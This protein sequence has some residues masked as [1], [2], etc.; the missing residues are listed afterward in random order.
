MLAPSCLCSTNQALLHLSLGPPTLLFQNSQDSLLSCHSNESARGLLLLLGPPPCPHLA[1]T[2]HM[3]SACGA[4]GL[5]SGQGGLGLGGGEPPPHSS[6]IV[7]LG[8]AP[9]E[10]GHSFKKSLISTATF[11]CGRILF[12][13]WGQKLWSLPPFFLLF[14]ALLRRGEKLSPSFLNQE[15]NHC[16]HQLIQTGLGWGR[17]PTRPR[18]LLHPSSGVAGPGHSSHKHHVSQCATLHTSRHHFIDS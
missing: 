9:I 15:P 18:P 6:N 10:L 1:T 14:H 7:S 4:L 2:L 8:S 11:T 3:D 17:T 13:T 5:Q 12:A 16:A